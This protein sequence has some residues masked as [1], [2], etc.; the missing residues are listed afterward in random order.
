MDG[1]V[2]WGVEEAAAFRETPKKLHQAHYDMDAKDA[3]A[4]VRRTARNANENA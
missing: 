3:P 1:F 4:V 2:A